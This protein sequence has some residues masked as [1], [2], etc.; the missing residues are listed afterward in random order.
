MSH[1]HILKEGGSR[2]DQLSIRYQDDLLHIQA[3]GVISKDRVQGAQERVD[4]L[5]CFLAEK[6]GEPLVVKFVLTP[7]DFVS[8]Q[9][10]VGIETTA[11][12]PLP[13]N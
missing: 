9:S 8:F 6:I 4:L 10:P 5:H 2:L 1:P 12:E 7:V 11:A 13:E 3:G